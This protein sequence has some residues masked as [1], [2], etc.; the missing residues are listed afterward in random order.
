MKL[1]LIRQF[2]TEGFT[3]GKLYIDD[4]FECYAVEDEDRHLEAGGT[5]V[6]GRTAI[7]KGSYEVVLSMSNRF[8]KLLPEVLNVPQFTGVR[9]HSGN[10]S[11]DSEGCIILGSTN[12]R[13]DDDWVGGSKIALTQFMAKLE[14]AKANN[15]KVYIEIS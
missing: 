9:I 4:V 7:P 2:G 3:E 10:S 14:T 5:K 11:K 8:K 15:E 13:D 1:K 12:D 6:Y